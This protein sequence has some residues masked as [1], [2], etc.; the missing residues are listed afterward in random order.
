MSHAAAQVVLA[1]PV[2]PAQTWLGRRELACRLSLVEVLLVSAVLSTSLLLTQEYQYGPSDQLILALRQMHPDYLLGDAYINNTVGFGPRYYFV[3]LLAAC[4]RLLPM[5]AV[6]LGLTWAANALVAAVT[7]V[8]TRNLCAGHDLAGLLAGGLVLSVHSFDLGAAGF[9]HRTMFMPQLLILPL[10]LLTLW[11][12]IAG[13]P[14]IAAACAVPAL[15]IHPLVGGASAALVLGAGFLAAAWSIFRCASNTRGKAVH[16]LLRYTLALAIVAVSFQLAWGRMSRPVLSTAQFIDIYAAF[17]NPHHCIPSQFPVLDY[18]QAGFF[19]MA[20]LLSW[21]WWARTATTDSAVARRT[22]LVIGLV[23]LACVGGYLFVEVW[24]SRTWA[25]AQTFRF[26]FVLKWLGFVL[27]ANTAASLFQRAD[28]R[29]ARARG[30]LMIAGTGAAQPAVLFV[31]HLAEWV[32][33]R[34]SR[35]LATVSAVWPTYV[36]C[37]LALGLLVVFGAG[38]DGVRLLIA[39]VVCAWF[40]IVRPCWWRGAAPAAVLFAFVAVLA[41]HH[42][43]PLPVVWRYLN[44]LRLHVTPESIGGPVAAIARVAQQHTPASAVLLT[45]PDFSFGDFRLLAERAIV[46]DVRFYP[47]DDL[48]MLEWRRRLDDCYG[49]VHQHGQAAREEMIANYDR[50]TDAELARIAHQYGAQYAILYADTPTALPPL[51]RTDAY[52]LVQVPPSA[53]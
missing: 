29:P 3:S 4:S 27:V 50:L 6:V 25:T 43:R 36:A 33:R 44:P 41:L 19:L 40:L 14:L 17:R 15:F 5:P 11:A 37:V 51:A 52:Q 1:D 47:F 48:Q 28:D 31:A 34:G 49:P 18:V 20:A 26:L 12:G 32:C 38:A 16:S 35:S 42:V 39:G 13:R 22:L 24:P 2:L 10:A 45:P 23:V 21:F 9:L 46:V 8:A 7:I 30:I 53:E